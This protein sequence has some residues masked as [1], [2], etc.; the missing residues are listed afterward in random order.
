VSSLSASDRNAVRVRDLGVTYRTTFEKTPTLRSA[1][2]RLGRRERAVR[3]IE[4]LKGVS[5]D[6]PHGTVLGIIGANG[7]GKSTLLRAIAGIIPPGAGRIEIRGR[8][9]TLLALGV[10]FNKNLSG[11]DNVVLGGLAA[12]MDTAEIQGHYEEIAAFAG[13]GDFMDLPMRTYSSGM[14]GRLAFAVAAHMNPDILLI[15]EALSTGDAAFKRKSFEKMRELCADARTLLLVSH[16]LG[17]VRELASQC[18]WLDRGRVRALGEPADVISQ[19]TESLELRDSVVT[20]ED[21]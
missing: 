16:G 5:F 15:D 17:T 21:V 12:G 4:A 9:T 8:V 10:G 6:V 19:Y 7:A 20:M 14:Y 11:R 3:V 18:L 13:L 2:V 1:L